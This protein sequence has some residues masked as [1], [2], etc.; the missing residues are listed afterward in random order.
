MATLQPDCGVKEA[1]SHVVAVWKWRMTAS[2]TNFPN[3]SH[4]TY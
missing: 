4:L 3:R 1:L 2:G